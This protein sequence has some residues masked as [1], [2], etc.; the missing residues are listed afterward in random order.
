VEFANIIFVVTDDCNYNCSY[1]PQVKKN[2]HLDFGDIDKAIDFFCPYLAEKSHISFYGG[3]P[4]LA[5][6]RIKFTVEKATDITK[7]Q[8]IAFEYS[9]STNGSL[10]NDEIVQFLDEYKF[11]VVLSFDGFAQE[12]SRKE[13]SYEDTILLI[14]NLLRQKNIKLMINSV[15]EPDTVGLLSKSMQMIAD[16]S[17]PE[18]RFNLAAGGEWKKSSIHTFREEMKS[19]RSFTKIFYKKEGI[20]PI[21]NFRREKRSGIFCCTGGEDRIAL[22]PEGSLWGCHLFWDYFKGKDHTAEY[23][24]YCFG[25]IDSFI[26][27]YSTIYPNIIRN[28]SALNQLNFRSPKLDCYF[29]PNLEDC[30]VCPVSAA[31]SSQKMGEIPLW[32]CETKKIIL[33]ERALLWNE[34][35]STG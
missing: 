22:T 6:D 29:C 10:L 21:D 11:F 31:F 4:L 33:R 15:F 14:K 18:I 16:M 28:Y 25:D 1:C 20:I 35:D 17:V 24:K 27:E 23:Q 12:K 5:F 34:L 26:K 9:L 19:L 30:G 13:A 7:K 3:E 32:T 8:P 2:K